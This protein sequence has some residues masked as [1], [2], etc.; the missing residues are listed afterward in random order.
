MATSQSSQSTQFINTCLD[1]H[2]TQLVLKPT[3]VSASS[4]NILD[5]I[6]TTNPDTV[7]PIIYIKGLSDHLALTFHINARA[8][9]KKTTKVIRDY[10]KADLASITAEM[11]NFAASYIAN[12]D[13]RCVEENW[14]IFKNKLLSLIERFVPQRTVACKPRSP[15]FNPFLKRLR[16]KKKR[17]FRRAKASCSDVAWSAY[18]LT[19]NDYNTAS[20]SAKQHFYSVTLPSIL[21]TNPRKFW[22]IVNGT[23][24][25][26]IQLTYPNDQP[27]APEEC[28]NVFN[29]VFSSHVTTMP[30]GLPLVSNSGFSPMDPI[31]IDWVGVSCLINNHKTSSSAGPD[32]L[33]SKI[34]KC[35]N[36]FSAVILSHIFTQS[37]QQ[38]V[39][40]H[41]WCVGKVIPVHKSGRART[42]IAFPP[43]SHS[44][45][46]L[47]T[48]RPPFKMP[49]VSIFVNTFLFVF[50]TALLLVLTPLLSVTPP[51][52]EST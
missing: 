8:P 51:G 42:G 52:L 1:F 32:C 3:R 43:Q 24:S 10:S 23:P 11:E 30:R 26:I 4:S 12:C 47:L 15:W 18:Y 44:S 22:T 36:V 14:C 48:S 40:P 50:F 6:L 20:A 13:Q 37:L 16:N 35:T 29:D 34:L 7:S 19:E 5:L 31:S 49:F 39:L 41:D 38:S 21:Q 46:T 2:F 27:V 28:C 17:L 25:K 45:P 9:V 33:N